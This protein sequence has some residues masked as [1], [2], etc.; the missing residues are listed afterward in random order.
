MKRHSTGNNEP[1]S[2]RMKNGEAVTEEADQR[3]A[4]A[5][6]MHTQDL[7]VDVMRPPYSFIS[8]NTLSRN[9]GAVNVI[10]IVLESEYRAR[11]TRGTMDWKLSIRIGD[12]T[13]RPGE[14]VCANL[15]AKKESDLPNPSIGDVVILRGVKDTEY[16]S[17]AQLVGRSGAYTWD[18]VSRKPCAPAYLYSGP[19]TEPLKPA[20]EDFCLWLLD[21][22]SENKD[23]Q[24]VSEILGVQVVK[25]VPEGRAHTLF[26]GIQASLAGIG[27]IDDTVEVCI[28]KL[29]SSDIQMLIHYT[30]LKV[31][32][33]HPY[34]TNPNRYT[35]WTTDYT[36]NPEWESHNSN[37]NKFYDWC[38][39]DLRPYLFRIEFWDAAAG[40]A[41]TMKDG[42]Y[43]FR[44]TCVRRDNYG[45]IEGRQCE[46]KITQLKEDDEYPHLK[47][48][49]RRREAWLKERGWDV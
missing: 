13:T 9:Y 30:T 20:E 41:R 2:K 10:G 19:G 32:A 1:D 26:S 5:S 35:V 18:I 40:V 36:R 17:A 29:L 47:A 49:L 3:D 48:L 16:Q 34:K 42:F 31:I 33:I 21:W 25:P 44:N 39:P 22:D 14:R 38:A 43:N 15:F 8:M 27:F 7:E 46:A 23:T 11:A 37:F 6:T 24:A 28:S 12:A 4:E 45:L